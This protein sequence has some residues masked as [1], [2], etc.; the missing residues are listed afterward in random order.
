MDS[1]DSMKLASKII[2]VTKHPVCIKEIVWAFSLTNKKIEYQLT[3]FST[4][5]DC[6]IHVFSSYSELKQF[7]KEKWNV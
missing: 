1:R 4:N 6:T 2:N 3:W 5:V 7:V